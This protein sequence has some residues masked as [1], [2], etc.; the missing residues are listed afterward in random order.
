MIFRRR[1]H[2]NRHSTP[3]ET[4]AAWA[5][6]ERRGLNTKQRAER[7]E[8]LAQSLEHREAYRTAAAALTALDRHAARPEVIALREAALSARSD[9]SPPSTRVIAAAMGMVTLAGILAWWTLQARDSSITQRPLTPDRYSSSIGERSTVTLPDGS[10]MVLNTSS[11]AEVTYRENERQVRLIRGQAL[12]TV[13]HGQS[14]PFRV[15]ASDRVITA[16]GTV[17]DVYLKGHAVQVS[18]IEGTVRVSTVASTLREPGDDRAETL[19]AG[20]TL[21]AA[22]HAPVL[23]KPAN[24]QRVA[25]WRAGLLIFEETRLADAIDEINRYTTNTVSIADRAAG[26]Y[27]VTG[28]FRIGEAQRFAHTMTQLFPLELGQTEQGQPLLRSK[29]QKIAQ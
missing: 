16:V 7:D 8:W 14:A 6:E 23:V 27:R 28:T 2:P 20:D 5:L 22:P 3:G 13:A 29:Q 25:S 9:R 10:V 4:A 15:Y 19:S 12:F 26:E 11:E 24:L 18:T 21:T 17:F 1:M